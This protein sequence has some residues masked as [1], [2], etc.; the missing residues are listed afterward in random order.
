MLPQ[1]FIDQFSALGINIHDPIFGAWVDSTHQSWSLAYN[2]AWTEFFRQ[3]ATPTIEQILD[4]AAQ[5]AQEFGFS[6]QFK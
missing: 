5:L 4:K 2:N 6:I 1:K 3:N